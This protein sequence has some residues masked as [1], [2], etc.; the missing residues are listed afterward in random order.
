MT[1]KPLTDVTGF[2]KRENDFN[3]RAGI[4]ADILA[5]YE[6]AV[7]LHPPFNSRHEGYAILLEELDE[8]WE[9][10]K[11]NHAKTPE[12]RN[13]MKKEA[14]QVAA[15]A[16]RFIEDCCTEKVKENW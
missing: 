15:M 1:E 16:I 8:L 11:V 14:V 6:R 12:C 2:I 4:I 3:R 13:D 7:K 5:E 10:V 9:I